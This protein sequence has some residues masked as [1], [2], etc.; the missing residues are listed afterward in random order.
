M[1]RMSWRGGGRGCGMEGCENE[2]ILCPSQIDIQSDLYQHEQLTRLVSWR[3]GGK[4]HD[5]QNIFVGRAWRFGNISIARLP[6][7]FSFAN[8]THSFLACQSHTT[9]HV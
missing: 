7:L 8:L 3:V 5:I 4:Y 9:K 2:G 6:S 1:R